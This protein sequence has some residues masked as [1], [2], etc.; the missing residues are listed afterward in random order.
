MGLVLDFT[1][2]EEQD[3]R[4]MAD[5]EGV[6]VTEYARR[7]LPLLRGNPQKRF[8]V[9][10]FEGVS[11]RSV[12]EIEE[13]IAEIEESRASLGNADCYRKQEDAKL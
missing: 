4:W 12:A 5:K 2:N 8:T 9:T 10:D 3:I 7:L 11:N 13:H 6:T 1:P